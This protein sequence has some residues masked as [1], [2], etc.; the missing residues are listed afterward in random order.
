MA[1]T[2]VQPQNPSHLPKWAL[3]LVAGGVCAGYELLYFSQPSIL[4]VTDVQGSTLTRFIDLTQILLP[5][6]LLASTMGHGR[7]EVGF[8]DRLPIWFGAGLWLFAAGVVG[9]PVVLASG[10]ARN[11][12][13]L[14]VA[15]LS[16]LSGLSSLST[17]T[18]WVGLAGGL[19]SRWPL[20]ITI[21]LAAAAAWL[22][23]RRIGRRSAAEAK[24]NSVADE[25][26]AGPKGAKPAE[27]PPPLQ[28]G[29]LP[30]VWLMR[31]IPVGVCGLS[32]L[33]LLGSSLPPWEFDVVEYHL[34]APKEFFQQGAV[35]FVPHN[36]YANMPL[37]AEMHVLGLMT[38]SGGSDGWWWGALLGKTILGSFSLLGAALLGA[39]VSR[40]VDRWAGWVAAAVWLSAPGT[41]HV[42]MAGLVDMVLAA[43]LLGAV[44]ALSELW[45]PLR[46]GQGNWAASFLV[47]QLAG[48]GAAIK[49]T[50]VIFFTL[51]I[52][53]ALLW[54]F[55]QALRDGLPGA[56]VRHWG[57]SL[58]VLVVGL[59]WSG[60]G[61]Y[62]KNWIWT[63]NPVFPL[64]S[65][66][67]GGGALQPDQIGQW[68]LAHRVPE[69][70]SGGA[71]SVPALWQAVQLLGWKSSFLPPSLMAL[72]LFGVSQI[73]WRDSAWKW[74]RWWL[75]LSLWV[76][77]VWW[78]ATHRIDRF[79]LPALPLL[80]ALASLGSHWLARRLSPVLPAA[81]VLLGLLYGGF[82]IMSGALGD[83]RF[84]VSLS[85]LRHDAGDD[86]QP[87]RI[88]PAIAWV[89]LHLSDQPARL[90]LIG[91]AKAF[92]F[93]V[94]IVYATCFDRNPG[95]QWLADQAAEQQLSNLQQAGI[96]HVL[97]NWSELARYRSPGNY[98]FSEWPQ[99]ADIQQLI[100]SGVLETMNIPLDSTRVEVL[101]VADQL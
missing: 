52:V 33:L 87:G 51:P 64:A 58:V 47:I 83:N 65:G 14:E 68:Q 36:I 6:Q 11:C 16:V 12:K 48:T 91:E 1:K 86:S 67:F 20:L 18:L 101:R 74:D 26:R 9:W 100:D 93:R 15:A 29:S 62:V 82:L 35:R 10:L 61:W 72:W 39:Y 21:F 41:A 43:Y 31:L 55:G 59:G 38:L 37:G 76:W 7:L 96:T 42:T 4:G 81:V 17:I 85:A 13:R 28:P 69:S 3:W 57:V 46:A 77:G 53:L 80:C 25:R 49:Y 95:E 89:N 56:A 88:A 27:T 23:A 90:L 40:R 44:V 92:D 73:R 78:L 97:V 54:A 60:G 22:V 98:G 50:G 71:Y 45:G 24:T 70:N 75:L 32:G 66:W 34:Q 2:L 63:G 99:R 8:L 79:W 94:P 30:A 84:F 19:G 5:E